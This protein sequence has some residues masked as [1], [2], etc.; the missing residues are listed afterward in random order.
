V[1]TIAEPPEGTFVCWF[2]P[3]ADPYAVFYRTDS[4]LDGSEDT[5]RW[6]NASAYEAH[7]DGPMSWDELL[8]EMNGFR[9]PVELVSKGELT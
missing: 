1:S 2:D 9:G 7:D 3:N 4:Y 8:N 6:Y 5:D